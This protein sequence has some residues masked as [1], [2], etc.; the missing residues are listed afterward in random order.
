MLLVNRKCQDDDKTLR[1]IKG[2]CSKEK[3]CNDRFDQDLCP[4]FVKIIVCYLCNDK[5]KVILSTELVI[6]LLYLLGMFIKDSCL[7][8]VIQIS[9]KII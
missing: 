6:C 5:Y 3:D 4:G 1:V 2:V 7:L 8:M 9:G